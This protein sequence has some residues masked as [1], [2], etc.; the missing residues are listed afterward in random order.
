MVFIISCNNDKNIYDNTV[1]NQQ[2]QTT[3]IEQHKDTIYKTFFREEPTKY[4]TFGMTVSE[5]NKNL[6]LLAQ[7]GILKELK[8]LNFSEY[9]NYTSQQGTYDGKIYEGYLPYYNGEYNYQFTIRGIFTFPNVYKDTVIIYLRDKQNITD[10]VLIGIQIRLFLGNATLCK[11]QEINQIHEFISGNLKYLAGDKLTKF[12]RPEPENSELLL[13]LRHLSDNDKQPIWNHT[14]DFTGNFH[15]RGLYE[16]EDFFSEYN[17]TITT[18]G[19]EICDVETVYKGDKMYY[20]DKPISIKNYS[21]YYSFLQQTVYSKRQSGIRVE[22]YMTD[23]EKKEI[24][25]KKKK[26]SE[27]ENLINKELK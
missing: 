2:I 9:S 16:Y 5:W 26:K 17:L 13:S 3:F 7:K 23:Y 6:A 12:K 19:T 27:T 24:T 8:E 25:D 15:Y 22:D 14:D 18:M 1:S 20:V 10:G 21:C 11:Y 4:G